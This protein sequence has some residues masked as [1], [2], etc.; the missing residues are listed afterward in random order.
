MHGLKLG[1]Y[2]TCAPGVDLS[3]PSIGLFVHVGSYLHILEFESW[4]TGVCS[5]HVVSLSDF[6]YYVI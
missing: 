5:L 3:V 1:V 6:A 2:C 4:I